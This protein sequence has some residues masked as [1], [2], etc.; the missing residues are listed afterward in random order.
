MELHVILRNRRHHVR[1]QNSIIFGLLP[2]PRLA[3]SFCGLGPCPFSCSMLFC[4]LLRLLRGG[5]GLSP[6]C[7]LPKEHL[8]SQLW[9]A[10]LGGHWG[11]WCLTYPSGVAPFLGLYVPWQLRRLECLDLIAWGYMPAHKHCG[12]LPTAG[13][14]QNRLAKAWESFVGP[15]WPIWWSLPAQSSD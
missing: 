5:Q 8:V 9:R 11:P 1:H 13:Q 3:W 6:E 14:P 15:T 4:D 12:L 7:A 10:L 2:I